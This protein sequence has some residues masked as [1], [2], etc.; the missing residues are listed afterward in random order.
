MDIGKIIYVLSSL[1]SVFCG[2]KYQTIFM[3]YFNHNC[4]YHY[5]RHV[6]ITYSI[7]LRFIEL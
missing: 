1:V 4:L 5:V 6:T 3:C 7:Y 2:F